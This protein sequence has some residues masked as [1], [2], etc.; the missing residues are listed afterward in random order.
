MT[1]FEWLDIFAGNLHELMQERGYSQG[2]LADDSGL[3][4]ATISRYLNRRRIPTVR[5]IVNL[6]HTLDC[7][8]SELIDFGDRIE[9]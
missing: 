5:A 3:D 1:E 7:D 4:Q 9:G 8:I 6:A 2:D